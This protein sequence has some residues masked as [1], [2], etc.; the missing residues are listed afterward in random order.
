MLN[1]KTD[2]YEPP[3]AFGKQSRFLRARME[4]SRQIVFWWTWTS[5]HRV[6]EKKTTWQIGKHVWP[7]RSERWLP[8]ADGSST[9]FRLIWYRRCASDFWTEQTWISSPHTKEN[10]QLHEKHHNQ[11]A[12]LRQKMREPQRTRRSGRCG[13]MEHTKPQPKKKRC[14]AKLISWH[15]VAALTCVELCISPPCH[16]PV[17]FKPAPT[18]AFQTSTD[19]LRVPSTMNRETPSLKT[20]THPTIVLDTWE[21]GN[22][23]HAFQTEDPW[24]FIRL[25]NSWWNNA[26]Q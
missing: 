4:L 13:A 22:Q 16:R 11:E 21:S 14:W 12:I 25:K 20:Y 5:M 1:N 15:L 6:D 8:S 7:Q 3:P 18:C 10:H 23:G 9:A 24:R 17:C 26:L 2:H 19:T